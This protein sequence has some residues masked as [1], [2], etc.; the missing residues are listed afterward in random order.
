MNILCSFPL[1]LLLWVVLLGGTYYVNGVRLT[2]DNIRN[3][4][5]LTQLRFA[6]FNMIVSNVNKVD[7]IYRDRLL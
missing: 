1:Q 4:G 6:V 5:I 7:K 3:Y 2:K